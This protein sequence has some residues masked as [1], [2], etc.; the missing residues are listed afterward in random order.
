VLVKTA[1]VFFL[2]MLI[3]VSSPL[4]S[5]VE[6]LLESATSW[7][8]GDFFYPQ[9]NAQISSVKLQLHKN[10]DAPFHCHP[11]PTMGFIAKGKVLLETP[12]GKSREYKAGDAVIEVMKNLHRGKALSDEAEIIVFYA[13]A[14]GI[15]NT[16][17]ESDKEA[18]EKYC[19]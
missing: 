16:V 9:G 8:G 15:P 7:D 3:L 1:K 14:K 5:A 2:A 13:G 18:F 17:F 19:R 11:V 4:Y 6:P 12:D 10:K